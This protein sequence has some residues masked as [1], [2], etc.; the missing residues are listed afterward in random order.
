MNSIVIYFFVQWWKVDSR[1][2]PPCHCRYLKVGWGAVKVGWGADPWAGEDLAPRW[3]RVGLFTLEIVLYTLY[4]LAF[5]TVL[6]GLYRNVSTFTSCSS[7]FTQLIWTKLT[8]V[9]TK[10]SSLHRLKVI[11][12]YLDKVLVS[13]SLR[14]GEDQIYNYCFSWPCALFNIWSTIIFYELLDVIAEK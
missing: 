10:T 14:S 4:V 13:G 7:K 12:T 3:K 11:V 6:H 1:I 5:P 2:Y 9:W 8:C